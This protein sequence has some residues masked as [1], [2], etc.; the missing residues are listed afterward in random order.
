MKSM[1]SVIRDPPFSLNSFFSRARAFYDISQL[2]K[3]I[4]TSEK[5]TDSRTLRTACCRPR[6]LCVARRI[7]KAE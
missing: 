5:I 6:L 2:L 4:Y 1:K 3:G 7:I